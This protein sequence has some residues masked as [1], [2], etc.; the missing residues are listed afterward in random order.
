MN[1]ALKNA[2]NNNNL[3]MN[4]LRAF[5]LKIRKVWVKKKAIKLLGIWLYNKGKAENAG[6]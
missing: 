5:T 1:L 6:F 3:N 2:S 4:L